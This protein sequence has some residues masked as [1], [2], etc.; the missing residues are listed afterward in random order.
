MTTA[1]ISIIIITILVAISIF[2]Y[3]VLHQQKVKS[4]KEQFHLWM[5]L[6]NPSG[7]IIK[8]TSFPDNHTVTV[9][10]R[11]AHIEDKTYLRL[12][13]EGWKPRMEVE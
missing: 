3:E 13:E 4:Y 5:E 9:R 11:D 8:V 12:M 10:Y 6:V 7:E 2:T 1:N